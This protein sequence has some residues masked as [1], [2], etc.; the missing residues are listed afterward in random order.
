MNNIDLVK[1]YYNA[2]DSSKMEQIDEYVSE[3]FQLIDFTRKPMDKA[4]VLEMIRLFKAAMPNLMHSLS[5]MRAED[6]LVKVTVQLAGT[7]SNHLD[8]RAMGIGVVPR[9]LKFIIF[10]NGNYEFTIRGGKI[11]QARD[12][13]PNSPNR[14]M[15]GML[16]AMGV[17][18]A[19]IY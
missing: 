11:T 8:L 13:S 19:T 12:V 2:L 10:P 17:N 16:K 7:N 1:A 6:D 18:V 14:R 5:N 15:S 3:D 9:T 4:A